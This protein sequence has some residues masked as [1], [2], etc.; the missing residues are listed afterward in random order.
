M[1][2]ELG[3]PLQSLSAGER[4]DGRNVTSFPARAARTPANIAAVSE[5]LLAAQG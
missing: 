5:R 1:L 2:K 3:I 4:P